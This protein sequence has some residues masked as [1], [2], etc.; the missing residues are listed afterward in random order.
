MTFYD[1]MKRKEREF[2]KFIDNVDVIMAK[3]ALQNADKAVEFLKA[4][5]YSGERSDG[6]MIEPPYAKNTIRQK[7]L[8]DKPT[9]RVTLLW[10]GDF[11]GSITAKRSGSELI[12]DASDDKKSML[13]SKYE[14]GNAKI[15]DLN[16]QWATTFMNQVVIPEIRIRGQ[17][18]LD[19]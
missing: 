9:N 16:K 10:K 15:L 14:R 17:K 5:L 11:Y 12:F 6:S 2:F 18:I 13:L 8:L 1:D 3:I 19:N 7:K 4:Q